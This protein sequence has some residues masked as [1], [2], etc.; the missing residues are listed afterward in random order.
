MRRRW[1]AC[2]R[3][4]G[5]RPRRDNGFYFLARSEKPS[6]RCVESRATVAYGM[7]EIFISS[8][9]RKIFASL[10][11]SSRSVPSAVLS[12]AVNQFMK[13]APQE[14]FSAP[15]RAA[16]ASRIPRGSA[17]P[18]SSCTYSRANPQ[19]Q[20]S[21]ECYARSSIQTSESRKYLKR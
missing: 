19:T 2:S 16:P 17:P 15:T 21:P 1:G 4:S 8:R 12:T 18:A 20:P 13:P 3:P 7:V 6:P 10:G 11:E 9:A 14:K 5:L